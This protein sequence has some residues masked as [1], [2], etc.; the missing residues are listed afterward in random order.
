MLVEEEPDADRSDGGVAGERLRDDR[1][2]AATHAQEA[3]GAD[4][5]SEEV[6]PGPI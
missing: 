3:S 1:V 2:E 6:G 5:V 4:V